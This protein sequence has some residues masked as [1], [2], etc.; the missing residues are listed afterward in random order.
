V[1]SALRITWVVCAQRATSAAMA[2]SRLIDPPEE[3]GW[4]VWLRRLIHTPS[5]Q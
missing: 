5:V 1:P 3:N 4:S 2:I